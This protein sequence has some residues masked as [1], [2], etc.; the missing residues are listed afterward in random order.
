MRDR[1]RAIAAL[2][3]HAL[4]WILATPGLDYMGIN[5]Y[6]TEKS[7]AQVV[8]N[9]GVI[10][11]QFAFGAAA[12]N[13]N[14]RKPLVD[15][16]APV[17]RPFRV[18]Q[19]WS[20][21]RDGPGQ[22][23]TFEVWVDDTLRFRTADPNYDWLAPQLRNRRVRAMVESTA[24]KRDSPNWRGL[25]RYIVAQAREDFPDAQGVQIKCQVGP[26]PGSQLTLSHS[27]VAAAPDW[28]ARQF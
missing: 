3:V 25:A 17:Q 5:D 9:V 20:L 24:M 8:Q 22:Y 27:I 19:E 2:G 6:K 14:I 21:Y 28:K 4:L 11:A 10:P 23:H 15:L 18:S 16:L 13:R 1:D 7:Q 12:F 26:Y